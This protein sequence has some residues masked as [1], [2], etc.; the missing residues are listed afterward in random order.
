MVGIYD[1]G[2]FAYA[3]QDTRDSVIH[4]HGRRSA[5]PDVD[6]SCCEPDDYCVSVSAFYLGPR[7]YQIEEGTHPLTGEPLQEYPVSVNEGKR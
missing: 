3:V 7:E 6:A 1:T 4:G 5:Q 2:V